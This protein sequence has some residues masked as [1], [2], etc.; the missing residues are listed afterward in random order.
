MACTSEDAVVALKIEDGI[1]IT[2]DASTEKDVE[3]QYR[4]DLFWK[5]CPRILR[6]SSNII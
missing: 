4:V 6:R 1:I 5:I 3:Q 2:S